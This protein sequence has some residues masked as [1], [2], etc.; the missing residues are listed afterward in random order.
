[1]RGIS[2]SSAP[3]STAFHGEW[4]MDYPDKY[5]VEK[6]VI[7]IRGCSPW[8]MRRGYNLTQSFLVKLLRSTEQHPTIPVLVVKIL[9]LKFEVELSS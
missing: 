7:I 3:T 1:M 6:A 5:C 2:S 8:P 4:G 9:G